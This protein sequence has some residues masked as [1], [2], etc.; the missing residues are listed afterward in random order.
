M[1]EVFD[2]IEAI[3]ER[4]EEYLFTTGGAPTHLSLSRGS[5]RRLIEIVSG[6]HA[7]GNLIIGCRALTQF[8]TTAGPVK[9]HIDEVL[10]DTGLE[11]H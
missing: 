8:Q 10:D 2:L 11:L 9:I 5:Y 4:V 7:I 3:N 6:E 1:N